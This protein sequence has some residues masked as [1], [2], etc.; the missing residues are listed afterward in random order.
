MSRHLDNAMTNIDFD[1]SRHGKKTRPW[2]HDKLTTKDKQKMLDKYVGKDFFR[3]AIESKQGTY[4]IDR[5]K[6]G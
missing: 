5:R 2:R 4:T 3:E 6:H 1:P